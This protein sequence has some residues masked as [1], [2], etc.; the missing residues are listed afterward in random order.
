[1]SQEWFYKQVV[2]FVKIYHMCVCLF[3]ED[4]HK[5]VSMESVP[6]IGTMYMI[7]KMKD[8]GI[9]F[10]VPFAIVLNKHFIGW[11]RRNR[12]SVGIDVIPALK[13]S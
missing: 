12:K 6:E 13:P 4:C 11:L 5:R 2:F 7:N 8:I 10:D 9:I 1:M 3:N